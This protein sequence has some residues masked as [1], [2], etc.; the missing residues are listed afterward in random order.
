MQGHSIWVILALSWLFCSGSHADQETGLQCDDLNVYRA[1]DLVLS[2]HNKGLT[3]GNQLALYQIIE[4]AQVGFEDIKFYYI[5]FCISFN[6]SNISS[7]IPFI[8]FIPV[9]EWIR[10]FSLSTFYSK[11]IQLHS[12]RR[13]NLARMWLSS[14]FLKGTNSKLE[15]SCNMASSDYLFI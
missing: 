13:Q 15:T 5:V 8:F 14:R 6:P 11:G 10:Q 1:V 12:R 3:E 2:A 9:P 7:W 4:A